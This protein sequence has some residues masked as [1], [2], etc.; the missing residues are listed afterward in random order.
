MRILHTHY[1]H[2]SP[3]PTFSKEPPELDIPLVNPEVVET[4]KGKEEV[5]EPKGTEES[6][7]EAPKEGNPEQ[8]SDGTNVRLDGGIREAS[9]WILLG[10]KTHWLGWSQ[11]LCLLTGLF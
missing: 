11:A 7:L 4:S 2:L 1:D 9:W 10:H 5:K 8:K 6:G 3:L